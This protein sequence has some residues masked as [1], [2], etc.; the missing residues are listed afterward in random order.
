MT[1]D[2]LIMAKWLKENKVDMVAMEST[3]SYWKP[4]YN[5]LE[6]EEVPVMLVNPQHIKSISGTKTDVRDAKWISGLLR[7]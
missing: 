4:I 1:D 5:I 7:H 2:L 6:C 3:G